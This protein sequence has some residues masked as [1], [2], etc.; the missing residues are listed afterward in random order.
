M[1]ATKKFSRSLRLER[2]RRERGNYA[3]TKTE[4]PMKQKHVNS[5]KGASDYARRVVAQKKATSKKQLAELLMKKW[6]AFAH[7]KAGI[8]SRWNV[9]RKLAAKN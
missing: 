4:K 2:A 3:V 1:T 7:D 5:I 6:P 9:A 8:D